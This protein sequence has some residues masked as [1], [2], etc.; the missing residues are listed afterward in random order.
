[1]ENTASTAD[2]IEQRRA[3]M[4][5]IKQELARR[6]RTQAWLIKRL[7]EKGITSISRQMMCNYLNGYRRVPRVLLAEA[8]T[9]TGT[10][11]ERILAAIGD[12]ALL[13]QSGNQPKRG[14]SAA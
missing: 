13:V 1:M 11:M 6:E 7:G 8:C 3:A 10:T 4:A 5:A 14:K 9:I 2:A 12:E